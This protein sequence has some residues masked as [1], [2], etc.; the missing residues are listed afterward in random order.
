MGWVA[1]AIIGSAIVGAAVSSESS[2]NA[3]NQQ[4]QAADRANAVAE[5]QYQQTREDNE[6]WRQ[7]GIGALGQINTGDF[8]R[9]FSASDYRQDPGYQFRLSEGQN[10]LERS[11]A[12][13]GSLNSGAT[14]KALTRYGQNVASE[15]FGNAYNRFNSDRDRRFNRLASIAGVGQTANAQVGA[16]GQN[17]SNAY[18]Q[19]SA[20][21]ANASSAAAVAQ[22]NA[23]NGA[24]STGANA[25]MQSQYLDRAYPKK[26]SAS[27]GYGSAG[28]GGGG[29]VYAKLGT[30]DTR[31][32][33]YSRTPAEIEARYGSPTGSDPTVGHFG[34][35]ML[36]G[37]I[38]SANNSGVFGSTLTQ[39]VNGGARG[40]PGN[41]GFA[42]D[43]VANGLVEEGRPVKGRAPVA[44]APVI[45]QVEL[46]RMFTRFGAS[47]R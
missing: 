40:A 46:P 34:M 36:G 30:N 2:S 23:I 19:N 22:G 33:D 14:L 13:R 16:A 3:A 1:V 43:A 44:A 15:E 47:R 4:N 5:R 21:A 8:Q 27:T 35:G 6:P 9:D 25:Y 28:G 24:I 31:M 10:A 41:Y 12:A 26:A 37:G 32:G 11:A 29:S 17:F 45:P 20:G 7:A 42:A 38:K 39:A 18:G